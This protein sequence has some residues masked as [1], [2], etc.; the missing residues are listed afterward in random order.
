MSS[1]APLDE[2]GVAS[3]ASATIAAAEATAKILM[4]SGIG[5]RQI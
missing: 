1:R 2:Y 4:L 3:S 5:D